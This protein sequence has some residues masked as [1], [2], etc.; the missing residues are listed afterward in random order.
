LVHGELGGC[1]AE[2][3][4]PAHFLDLFPLDKAAG[5]KILDFT[6]DLTIETG[7]IELLDASDAI[8]SLAKRLPA[9]LG[10]KTEGAHQPDSRY[11][12]SAR[13]ISLRAAYFFFFA[14]M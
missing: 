5:I 1:D 6:R 11:Y 13:Q 14:S 3:N 2:L 9:L 10:S 12:N 7:G 8:A 4:K